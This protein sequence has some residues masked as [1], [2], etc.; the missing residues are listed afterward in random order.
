VFITSRGSESGGRQTKAE[1]TQEKILA[2]ARD[3][4]GEVG[5]RRT[6]VD[7][8]AK[9]AAVSRGTVYLYF[10]DKQ[11]LVSATLLRNSDTLRNQLAERLDLVGPLCEQLAVAAEFSV[12]PQ[13]GGLIAMLR[14]REPELLALIV[15]TESH[16][17]IN[18]S[19]QFWRPRLQAAQERGE[20]R[21][22]LDL[23]AAAEWVARTLYT[24]S[25]VPSQRVDLR[26][27]RAGRIGDYMR[28][29]LLCGLGCEQ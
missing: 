22:G 9:R 6:S 1:V 21:T 14:E 26:T 8:V 28:E 10:T 13:P 2:A 24:A 7:A 12:L 3:L 11:A 16:S 18:K 19:A 29:F 20:L 15:L 4:L 23:D 27:S 17:W 25:V 5:I